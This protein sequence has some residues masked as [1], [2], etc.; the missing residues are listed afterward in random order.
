MSD[1]GKGD[2]RRPGQGYEDGHVRIWGER[3][4]VQYVPPPLEPEPDHA[5][6]P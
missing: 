6:T 2:D 3:Q 4:R 1:G 5:E